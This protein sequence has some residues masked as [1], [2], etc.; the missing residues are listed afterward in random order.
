MAPET[1][2]VPK[3]YQ[4]S[5]G[6]ENSAV[7]PIFPPQNGRRSLRLTRGHAPP[8]SL[9]FLRFPAGSS[10]GKFKLHLNLRKLSAG[11]S[12]SLKENAILA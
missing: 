4:Y 9:H 6:T 10:G 8:Y 12:L 3:L 11:G 2:K 5:F 7:P 1:K